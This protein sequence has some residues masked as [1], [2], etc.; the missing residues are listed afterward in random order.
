MIFSK[1]CIHK[2]ENSAERKQ[3]ILNVYITSHF[4]GKD[5]LISYKKY[6]R[7]TL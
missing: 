5:L 4:K 6:K 7:D 2:N 1:Y 3:T